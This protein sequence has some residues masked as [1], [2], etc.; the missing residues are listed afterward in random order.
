[1]S[2]ERTSSKKE[3]PKK[4]RINRILSLAGLASR[5]KADELIKAG[6]I[7]INGLVIRELGTRARWGIDSIKVDGQEI[8]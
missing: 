8:R 2:P 5:R 1:M 4:E 3:L 7:R 6:R